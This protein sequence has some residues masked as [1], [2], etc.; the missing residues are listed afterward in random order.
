MPKLF[1]SHPLEGGEEPRIV[2]MRTDRSVKIRPLR[3]IRGSFF[4][5]PSAPTP[6]PAAMPVSS[7]RPFVSERP[8]SAR[9]TKEGKGAADVRGFG[10]VQGNRIFDDSLI[11]APRLAPAPHPAHAPTT[12]RAEFWQTLLIVSW[13]QTPPKPLVEN[14]QKEESQECRGNQPADNHNRHRVFDFV[15]G[16]ITAHNQRK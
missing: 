2:R 14:R 7:S 9:R 3:C 5:L 13:Q 8:G 15:T 16:Q 12:R 4:T 10:S 1:L 11:E 6:N